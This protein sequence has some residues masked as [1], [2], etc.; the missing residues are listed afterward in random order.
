MYLYYW[1]VLYVA[2]RM[3]P[4]MVVV[5]PRGI[6]QL[7]QLRATLM[8]FDALGRISRRSVVD[9][10]PIFLYSNPF[11]IV[12]ISK[13]SVLYSSIL[14]NSYNRVTSNVLS[15]QRVTLSQAAPKSI[16]IRPPE[17]KLL[18]STFGVMLCTG[19]S[20]YSSM[21]TAVSREA[22]HRLSRS[23]L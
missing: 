14:S 9:L 2:I 16:L 13:W 4:K 17:P 15:Q 3:Q 8:T 6:A 23:N 7:A 11:N 19:Q 5:L 18:W 20:S 21:S 1:H 10:Q 12:Y 22:Y